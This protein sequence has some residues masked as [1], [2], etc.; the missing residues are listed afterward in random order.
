MIERT[1]QLIKA[2]GVVAFC[3]AGF[4]A[5]SNI[6]TFRGKGG[7]WEKY[8]PDTYVSIEGIRFLLKS[9]PGKLKDFIIEC[10]QVMLAAS[11]HKAH[12]SLADLESGGYLTGV[13][14]QNI[15]DLQRQAGSR[16]LAEIHGNA[17]VFRCPSCGFSLKKTRKEWADFISLLTT[18]N[19][20]HHIRRAILDFIGRCPVCTQMLESGVVFF[21]QALPQTE[22][23]KSF[24]YLREAKTVLCIGTSGIVYPAASLPLYA[25]ER[26][27]CII[28]VNPYSSNLDAVADICIHEKAGNFFEKLFLH[29]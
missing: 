18:K 15:D 23:D 21:G 13:I 1:A 19:I 10:F 28:N 8:D 4:S 20:P 3:G 7:L 16:Q 14:T 26:G 22:L 11:P 27:A 12:H 5:E 6:P 25:K 24:G 9:E 2:K 17:Y 29:L